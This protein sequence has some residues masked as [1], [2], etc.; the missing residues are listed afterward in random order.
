MNDSIIEVE[1]LYKRYA[2]IEALRSVNLSVMQ[3]E[4]LS[5]VGPD[6][7]G[8]TTL[9]KVLCG[10]LQPSSGKVRIL[11]YD[12]KDEL[13]HIK[14]QIGYL[15]QGFSL[16]RD[17]SIDENI[18]FF[19][20]IYG[21]KNFK[22]RREE[23]L[24]LTRLMPFRKRLAEHLSGGMKKKLALTCTLIHQPSLIFLDE[25]TT[26]VDPVS[27][28]DFWTL[29]SQLMKTGI[30]IVMTSP[31][32][33][34]AER[35][36]RVGLLESGTLMVVDAPEKIK[37]AMKGHVIE[38]VSQQ[39]RKAFSI[40]K[41]SPHAQEVQLFGDRLNVIVKEVERDFTRIRDSLHKEGIVIE[42]WRSISPSL[43]NAFISLM[44]DRRG[45]S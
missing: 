7:A 35:S 37:M 26:G 14:K 28:R 16:Y 6:G 29:L 2:E 4:M 3:G 34:E 20:G 25:P 9:L 21:V 31:Y 43:E 12:L 38:I 8:K 41:S 1:D 45:E 27:R 40:L 24:G 36:S 10:L 17:L 18:E 5:I 23:L 13:G 42:E 15:S 11:G 22:K 30:T 19:A 33:D 32:L 44:K 39:T